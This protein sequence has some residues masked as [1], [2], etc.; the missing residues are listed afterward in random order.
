MAGTTKFIQRRRPSRHCGIEVNDEL[1]QLE[2][3]LPMLADLLVAGGRSGDN[4]FP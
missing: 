4:H 1:G 2:R 3:T